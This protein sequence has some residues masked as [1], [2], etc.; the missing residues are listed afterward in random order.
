MVLNCVEKRELWFSRFRCFVFHAFKSTL[1]SSSVQREDGMDS[2]W[3]FCLVPCVRCN[4]DGASSI[5]TSVYGGMQMIVIRGK[6]IIM[7]LLLGYLRGA[8]D[9]LFQWCPEGPG[10]VWT[11]PVLFLQPRMQPTRKQMQRMHARHVSRLTKSRPTCSDR[12]RQA[13]L[14]SHSGR[15]RLRRFRRRWSMFSLQEGNQ[16]CNPNWDKRESRTPI[17]KVPLIAPH[18]HRKF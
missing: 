15:D 2:Y 4:F 1:L 12:R 5:L 18:R 6:P 9:Y 13:T 14:W 10:A 11:V 3:Y 17:F 7:N 16:A 8:Y